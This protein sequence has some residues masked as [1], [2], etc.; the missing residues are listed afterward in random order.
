[1]SVPVRPVQSIQQDHAY[2]C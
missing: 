2:A 1:M